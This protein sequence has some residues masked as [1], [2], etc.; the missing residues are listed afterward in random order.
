MS[1][2]AIQLISTDF[3]GTLHAEFE[4]PPVPKDL[5]QQIAEL[6]HQGAKWIINTGRDLSSLMESLARARLSIWPD[7]LGLVEREI[8][9]RE[10]HDYH[11]CKPWNDACTQDH[12]QLFERVRPDVAGLMEWVHARHEATLYEDAFSPL[13]M[14]AANNQEADAIM[15]HL[16]DYCRSVPNLTVVRNDIYARFSHI[17]YDKGTVVA[18]VGRQLG[19]SHERIFAAG[20]HLNDLP[21]LNGKH[22]G[23]MAAPAN[24][25]PEVQALIQ[26][27]GGF[28]ATEP[29][30]H[31]V[32]QALQHYLK[33]GPSR[34]ATC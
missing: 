27:T 32:A 33:S 7:Y 8:Y 1:S 25:I 14:I 29:W 22:A 11:P 10:G 34:P 12:A 6:Q 23:M 5:E 19:V 18:E 4:N 31:G 21:M 24:A 15:K 2:L 13:C 3:D 20:D 9:I 30:G 28:L 26:T 16:E 17:K